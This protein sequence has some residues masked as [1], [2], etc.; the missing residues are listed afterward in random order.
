M[1]AVRKRLGPSREN[2]V[3]LELMPD[4]LVLRPVEIR[5]G[6]AIDRENLHKFYD[7]ARVFDAS[8]KVSATRWL[9]GRPYLQFDQ[10]FLIFHRKSN[11]SPKLPG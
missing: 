4:W 11:A 1:V 3:C 6:L 5:A 8:A 9:P 7:L 2:Q 10:T